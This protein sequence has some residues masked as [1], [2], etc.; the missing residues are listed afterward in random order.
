[1]LSPI[2]S[3]TLAEIVYDISSTIVEPVAV[4]ETVSRWGGWARPAQARVTELAERVI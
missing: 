2:N 3:L 4:V 1:L